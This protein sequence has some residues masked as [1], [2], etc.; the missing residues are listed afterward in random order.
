M[1]GRRGW[2]AFDLS[3]AI[4]RRILFTSRTKPKGA[5]PPEKI[6]FCSAKSLFSPPPTFS[7]F[8]VVGRIKN[9]KQHTPGK[10]VA[11]TTARHTTS[12]STFSL[13]ALQG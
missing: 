11:G 2:R 12:N 4:F 13:S 1:G 3:L 6:V 9:S 8:V 5:S 7:I 10:I